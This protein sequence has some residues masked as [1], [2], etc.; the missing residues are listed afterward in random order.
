MARLQAVLGALKD[1][2]DLH[3]EPRAALVRG[4]AATAARTGGARTAIDGPTA[5]IADDA[6]LRVHVR[7]G[8]RRAHDAANA[9]AT[10]TATA[11]LTGRAA[12]VT[13]PSS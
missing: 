8:L 13:S 11:H 3:L 2:S 4:T 10:T 6:A 1:A 12:A 9:G 7:A 5:A